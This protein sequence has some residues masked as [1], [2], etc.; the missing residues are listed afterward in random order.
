MSGRNTPVAANHFSVE[1]DGAGTVSFSEVSGLTAEITPILYR[2]GGDKLPWSKT[3]P[4]LVRFHP[5]TLKRG[6]TGD[7]FVVQWAISAIQGQAE[8]RMVTISLLDEQY[9]PVMRWRLRNAWVSRYEAPHLK[10]SGNEI[11][12]ETIEL[13]H[14][15]LDILD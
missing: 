9:A 13:T 15:G 6:V 8:R 4:G 3:I 11:A 2:D 14:D 7:R 1:I 10:A 5:V 12:I